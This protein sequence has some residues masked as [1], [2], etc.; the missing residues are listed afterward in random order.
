MRWMLIIFVFLLF[1]AGVSAAPVCTH[2]DLD[3]LSQQVSLPMGAKIVHKKEQGELCEVVLALDGELV[4]LY[5]GKDFLLAG[6]LFKD[7]KFITRETLE[8][9]EN[10]ARK[11]RTRANE[12]KALEKE[13]RRVFFQQNLKV[14]EA[15][16]LFSFKPGKA[17]SVLYVVT[18]PNCS[19][20]KKLLPDLELVAMENHL[21][22]KVILFPL[23]GPKSREMA[24][25]TICGKLSYEDYA[26]IKFQ[27]DTPGC[28]PADRLLEKTMGFFSRT[29]LSFVPVVISGDAS[30]VVE[31]SNIN[32]VKQNLGLVCEDGSNVSSNGCESVP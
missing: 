31:G 21:E 18:D 5:A 32:Q 9:L 24:I 4:P 20:C 26:Q 27:P 10:V 16:T 7:K 13:S 6:K 12:K 30:W 25:Q 29:N 8:T 23:L 15:L 22:I 19:H 2:V 14:L 1:S 17:E 28:E 3:W 11:E